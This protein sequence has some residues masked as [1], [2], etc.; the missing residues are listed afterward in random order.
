MFTVQRSFKYEKDIHMKRSDTY[1]EISNKQVLSFEKEKNK[2]RLT[3]Y[4]YMCPNE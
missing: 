1:I 2:R 3:L 4:T